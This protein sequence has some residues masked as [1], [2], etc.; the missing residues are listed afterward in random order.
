MR[1][2]CERVA[3]VLEKDG[4]E[5]KL[6]I[7]ANPQLKTINVYDENLKKISIATALGNKTAESLQ[8]SKKS[9]MEQKAEQVKKNGLSV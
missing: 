8:L 9:S 7:E 1:L 6:F 5:Q 2:P 3:V 4:K